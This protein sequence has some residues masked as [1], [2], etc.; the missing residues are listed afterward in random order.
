METECPICYD[1]SPR[2]LITTKCNHSFHESCLNRWLQTSETCP[3]CI[4][5]VVIITFACMANERRLSFSWRDV[6]GSIRVLDLCDNQLTHFSFDDTSPTNLEELYLSGNRISEFSF[7]HAPETLQYL[8]LS[9]NLL[10]S[11]SILDAP[12]NLRTLSLIKNPLKSISVGDRTE[13][14][15]LLPPDCERV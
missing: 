5:R 12:R 4:R 11:F 2:A 6:C 8:G 1:P 10:T 9:Q 7:S 15:L 14:T 13:I 3:L